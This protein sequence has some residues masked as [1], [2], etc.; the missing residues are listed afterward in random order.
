[1]S[2]TIYRCNICSKIYYSL[3]GLISHKEEE[4]SGET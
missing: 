1:M 2:A 3:V 4:H